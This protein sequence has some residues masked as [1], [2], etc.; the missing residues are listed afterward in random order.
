MAKQASAAPAKPGFI[1]RIRDFISEVK[2]EMSKVTW[3]QW[4]ELKHSTAIVLFMLV[5]FATIIFGMDRVF[6]TIVMQV[7]RLG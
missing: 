7:L 1:E 3:P 6:N 4:E 2:H 5:L